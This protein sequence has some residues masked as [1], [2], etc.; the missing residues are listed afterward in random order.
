VLFRSQ[1][2][3]SY[4][5]KPV[6]R[7]TDESQV[8]LISGSVAATR[9]TASGCT[10]DANTGAGNAVYLYSG[11]VATPDDVGGAGSQPLASA[12][13]KLDTASGNYR[14]TLAYLPIGSYT[15]ALTCQ[16]RDDAPDT[17][18][19]IVFSEPLSA[20]VTAGMTTTV[21]FP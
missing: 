7:V 8:G 20:N 15:L 18:E 16:A 6:L 11:T 13:V 2:Q 19:A 12:P 3:S 10:G 5:L 21:N 4:T 1:G 9:I 17:D 14:Y